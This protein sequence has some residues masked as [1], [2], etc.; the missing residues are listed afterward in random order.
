MKKVPKWV[1]IVVGGLFV[2]FVVIG[3]LLPSEW[4]VSRSIVIDAPPERVHPFVGSLAEWPRWSLFDKED[5]DMDVGDLGADPF[6]RWTGTMVEGMLGGMFERG[7]ADLE[8]LAEAAPEP[9]PRPA[10]TE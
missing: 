4:Q 9:K 3:F 2:L 1:G 7:L 10:K 5:P 8:A 6:H